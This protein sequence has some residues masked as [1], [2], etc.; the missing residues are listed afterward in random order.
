MTA[1]QRQDITF[2]PSIFEKELPELTVRPKLGIEDRDKL[3]NKLDSWVLM[4]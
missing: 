1:E 3:I 4:S 2:K